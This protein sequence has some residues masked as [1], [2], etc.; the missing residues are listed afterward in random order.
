MNK[1]GN[2]QRFSHIKSFDNGIF[3]LDN[4]EKIGLT[5]I[6]GKFTYLLERGDIITV[7]IAQG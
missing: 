7:N 3:T 6:N 4:D 5:K 2:V 1:Y